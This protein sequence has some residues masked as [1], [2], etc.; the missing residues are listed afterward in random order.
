MR[1]G[2]SRLLMSNVT[3]TRRQQ[4]KLG[5]LGLDAHENRKPKPGDRPRAFKHQV[6]MEF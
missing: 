2:G 5:Y 6:A 3:E 1:G 4:K